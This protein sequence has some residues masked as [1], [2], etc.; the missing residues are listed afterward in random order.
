MNQKFAKVVQ[1]MSDYDKAPVGSAERS[2][3]GS[4][5]D[6]EGSKFDQRDYLNAVAEYLK[7]LSPEDRERLYGSLFRMVQKVLNR[8]T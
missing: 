1:L 3:I 5:L 6:K 7:S 4:R 8:R 2:E